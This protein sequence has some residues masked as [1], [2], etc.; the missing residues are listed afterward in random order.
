MFHF[1]LSGDKVIG[2]LEDREIFGLSIKRDLIV[3]FV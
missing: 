3:T 2:N 1:T